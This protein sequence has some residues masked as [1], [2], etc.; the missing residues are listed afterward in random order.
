VDKTCEGGEDQRQLRWQK[1][2][3]AEKR[4]GRHVLPKR[5][6]ESERVKAR[7]AQAR[8]E[9]TGTLRFVAILELRA[10]Y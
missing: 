10:A 6:S 3:V 7:L 8:L 2:C 9:I 1:I 4:R 5:A